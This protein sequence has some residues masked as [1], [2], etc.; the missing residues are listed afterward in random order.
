MTMPVPP[1]SAEAS[2]S[3]PTGA[4]SRLLAPASPTTPDVGP[5]A[6]LSAVLDAASDGIIV[7]GVNDRVL[8][9][10]D[11]FVE[12][13]AMPRRVLMT[14]D[15]RQVLAAQARQ[16]IDPEDFVQHVDALTAEPD[17][18]SQGICRFL[19]GRTVEHETR[20]VRILDRQ[21]G[22]VWTFRDITMRVQTFEM[23]H[24][25]EERFRVFAD[26]AAYGIVMH[27]NGEIVYANEA[28][29][30][31][32]GF[33]ATGLVGL[34]VMDFI[35]EEDRDAM[36]ERASARHMARGAAPLHYEARI[37]RRDGEV[38][39]M[40][41]GVSSIWLKGKMAIVVT[42]VDVTEKRKAEAAALH[43]A[44]HDSLTDLPNRALFRNSIEITI[45][46]AEKTGGDVSVLLIG[47]DRFKSANFL[48]H[49]LGDLVLLE[50]AKR[51]LSLIRPV[52]LV[53]RLGAD[54]FAVLLR[55]CDVGSTHVLAQQ[56][57]GS[58]R[59]P[60]RIAEEN[61]L[62]LS[63]SVGTASFPHDAADTSE[64]LRHANIALVAAKERGRDQA[65]AFES[66][67]TSEAS[68]R[69]EMNRFLHRSLRDHAFF[70]EFQPI[71]RAQDL[72]VTGFEA[73]VRSRDLLGRRVAPDAFIPIAEATGLVVPMGRVVLDL[74]L[75][76]IRELNLLRA[77]P[78]RMAI[79]ASAIQLRHPSFVRD[80]RA[81]LDTHGLPT[82]SLAVEI[83]ETNALTDPE[84]TRRVLRELRSA[85]VSISL[86]DFGTGFAS[87][88]LLRSLPLDLVKIDR[89]FTRDI[90]TDP[91]QAA[92]A[93]SVIDL[94]HQLGLKVVAEGVETESQQQFLLAHGC[95]L[96]QGYWLARPL[97]LEASL[98]FLQARERRV[99]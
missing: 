81:G 61:E 31:D 84:G 88:D 57:V 64:L 44:S 70:L 85:G 12:I 65:V 94:S 48:G 66:D 75:S 17:A 33:P 46:E 32:L 89:S 24:E 56:I 49:R 3:H 9:Y 80:I 23:L 69:L 21:V 86:D 40:Q 59:E 4:L 96:I 47:L 42:L 73:L 30:R 7:I 38:R 8:T 19:D 92:I 77:T 13:W 60:Y 41:L 1:E 72:G 54:E 5:E 93:K 35:P 15:D 20:P 16:L 51:L 27:Q 45:A 83:T 29:G 37:R 10:N 76:A 58:L 95:D 14:R 18:R 43:L 67:L 28:A 79:N 97:S 11:R 91:T 99:R 87:L 22:R 82:S 50:A 78:L 62:F 52:D 90:D 2:A 36:R 25:S 71:A 98:E 26:N 63:A 74:A 55:G 53:A 34:K 68:A 39:L 6:L